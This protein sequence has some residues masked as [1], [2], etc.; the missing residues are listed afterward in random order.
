MMWLQQC[1]QRLRASRSKQFERLR[2]ESTKDIATSAVT[3]AMELTNESFTPSSSSHHVEYI[4]QLTEDLISEG[5]GMK[6]VDVLYKVLLTERQILEQYMNDMKF[7]E[8]ADVAAID[9]SQA[10]VCPICQLLVW[11]PWSLQL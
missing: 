7:S 6:V 4:D 2:H 1:I 3:Q 8:E 10:V 9:N 11:L 5:D